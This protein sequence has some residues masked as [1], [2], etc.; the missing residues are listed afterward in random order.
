MSDVVHGVPDETDLAWHADRLTLDT[1]EPEQRSWFRAMADWLTD[2]WPNEPDY[3]EY[4]DPEEL[5]DVKAELAVANTTLAFVAKLLD[6]QLDVP[7]D[8]ERDIRARLEHERAEGV[9]DATIPS[10]ASTA[11]RKAL[12]LLVDARVAV[13]R[14]DTFGEH[15]GLIVAT[16]KSE[17]GE[18]Y[19]LGYDPHRK[20][21]RCTCREPKGKCSHLAALKQIVPAPE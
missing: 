17:S 8:V 20:Q 4:A 11:Q 13:S 7:D 12:R 3:A 14:L 21:W 6:L 19:Q 9:K 2:I 10:R 1:L 5:D 16:C 15:K 18:T